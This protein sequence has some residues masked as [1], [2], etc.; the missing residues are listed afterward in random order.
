MTTTTLTKDHGLIAREITVEDDGYSTYLTMRNIGGNEDALCASLRGESRAKL[1]EALLPENS[2]VITD[3]PVAKRD[4]DGWVYCGSTGSWDSRDP[5]K[6]LKNAK[7]LLA[8]HALIVKSHE[9]QEAAKAAAE[10]E[11]AAVEAARNKRRDDLAADLSGAR[12]GYD[13]RTHAFKAAIDRIIELE[14]AAK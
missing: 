9:E 12:G 13:T 4:V 6:V 3:L 8:I 14:E 1:A 2:T 7:E 10:A 5:E 11:K